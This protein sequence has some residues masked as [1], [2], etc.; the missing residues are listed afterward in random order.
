M[1]HPFFLAQISDLHLG[2]P[3]RDGVDPEGCLRAVVKALRRLPDRPDA[4]LVSGDL[5]EHAKPKQYRQGAKMIGKLGVPLYALP[6]NKDDRATMRE[7]LGHPGEGDAPLDYA[8]D[9]GPLRL[10][11]VDTTIPGEDRGGFEPGQLERLDA[12]LAASPR[13][14]IVAMHHPPL[15]TAMVDWDGVNLLL[16]ERGALAEVIARH[17]QVKAIVA[18]HLHRVAVSTLAGRPVLAAPSTYLQARPDFAR[19]KVKLYGG[20]PGF[21]VHALRDEELST[22]VEIVTHA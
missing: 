16:P 19:E 9:L 14:A 21:V 22:Q 7:V 3:A 1:T 13:P 15:T 6:G 11:V 2:E 10:I 17:P 8:V 5:A 20:A 12:E 18:G 4:I